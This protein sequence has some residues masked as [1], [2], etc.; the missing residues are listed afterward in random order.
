LNN[1]EIASDNS[2]EKI[3]DPYKNRLTAEDK[4]RLAKSK[5]NQQFYSVTKEPSQDQSRSS[6]D[7]EEQHN[8]LE[9][10]RMLSLSNRQTK[11]WDKRKFELSLC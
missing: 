5:I 7:E 8:A 2:N 6:L 10:M 11:T 3:I 1:K 9:V 4:K